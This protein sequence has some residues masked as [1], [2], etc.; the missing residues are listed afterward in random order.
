[1]LTAIF[2]AVWMIIGLVLDV[3]TMPFRLVAALLSGVEFEFRRFGRRRSV[4][5]AR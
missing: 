4:G 5:A 2:S 3:V 1:M